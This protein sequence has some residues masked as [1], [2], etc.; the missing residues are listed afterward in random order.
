[1]KIKTLSLV[2]KAFVWAGLIIGI[3]YILYL[4]LTPSPIILGIICSLLGIGGL[5]S[6]G[7]DRKRGYITG[8]G[9]GSAL[10]TYRK[11][12]PRR[13]QINS[14]TNI[15]VGILFLIVGLFFF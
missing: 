13:F 4:K 2:S 7:I 9:F 15:A 11:D 6:D 1:M 3:F 12:N 8:R 14:I 10:T 5:I